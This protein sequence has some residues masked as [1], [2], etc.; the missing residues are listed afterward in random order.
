[1]DM[2][3]AIA[4]VHRWGCHDFTNCHTR[5]RLRVSRASSGASF[6]VQAAGVHDMHLT[7]MQLR[8]SCHDHSNM[9]RGF[10]FCGVVLSVACVDEG[11]HASQDTFRH[12]ESQLLQLAA[13]QSDRTVLNDEATDAINYLHSRCDALEA[14]T[15]QIGGRCLL[16]LVCEQLHSRINAESKPTQQLVRTPHGS[17]NIGH[18]CRIMLCTSW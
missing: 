16:R 13:A 4:L 8:R 18:V 1:M 7:H 15:L 5:R 17:S 11:A 10:W 6:S 2:Q 12:H 3:I 14:T 9:I